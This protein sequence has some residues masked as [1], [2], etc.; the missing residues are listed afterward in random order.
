[1]EAVFLSLPPSL[2]PSSTMAMSS[3]SFFLVLL[4][5]SP[6]WLST[7]EA[8]FPMDQDPMTSSGAVSTPFFFFSE[9]ELSGGNTKRR[10]VWCEAVLSPD[11]ASAS[12]V[13]NINKFDLGLGRLQLL[14][15]LIAAYVRPQLQRAVF[16]QMHVEMFTVKQMPHFL[17]WPVKR[18]CDQ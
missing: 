15:H 9:L 12:N 4:F 10:Q 13:S 3:F 7:R 8:F 5:S 1:M 11:A 16:V 14:T 6:D 18:A 17:V 2:S